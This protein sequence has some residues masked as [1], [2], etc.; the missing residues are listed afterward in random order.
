MVSIEAMACGR[1]VVALGSGA[2]SEVVEPGVTGYL[3]HDKNERGRLVWRALQLDRQKI[4][5]RVTTKFE[6]SVV[7]QSYLKLYE[8]IVAERN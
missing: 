3:R 5:E 4:R 1:P 2:L 8:R 6:L 7:A